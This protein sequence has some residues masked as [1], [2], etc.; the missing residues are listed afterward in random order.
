M[1]LFFSHPTSKPS[2]NPVNYIQSYLTLPSP[3]LPC[4]YHGLSHHHTSLRFLHLVLTHLIATPFAWMV[5]SPPRTQGNP[6]KCSLPWLKTLQKF[7]FHLELKPKTFY[8][9]ATLTQP[10]HLTLDILPFHRSQRI[11]AG[12]CPR[13]F[14]SAFFALS[15]EVSSLWQRFGLVPYIIQVSAQASLMRDGFPVHT[16]LNANPLSLTPYHPYTVVFFSTTLSTPW[17]IMYP[18]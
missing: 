9:T 6:W 4:Y 17:P 3:C 10:A 16:L 7:S 2:A 14:G 15:Q 11:Q 5:Y 8:M 13:G 18:V 12:S 1:Y